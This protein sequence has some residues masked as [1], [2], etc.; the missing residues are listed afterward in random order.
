MTEMEREIKEWRGPDAGETADYLDAVDAVNR[1]YAHAEAAEY[2]RHAGEIKS[3][4]EEKAD[5]LSALR[6][7]YRLQSGVVSR[8]TIDGKRM[9]IR[10]KKDGREFLAHRP[11]D[12]ESDIAVG[13]EVGLAYEGGRWAVKVVVTRDIGQFATSRRKSR[14]RKSRRI[15]RRLTARSTS[16]RVS[17]RAKSLLA[18]LTTAGTRSTTKS[19]S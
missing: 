7:P 11:D 9:T 1:S 13:D 18:C 10:R 14:R 8:M 17:R 4:A 2:Q 16:S 12:F 6:N 3:L 15:S 5:E 19:N